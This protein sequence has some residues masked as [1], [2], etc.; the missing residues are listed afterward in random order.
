LCLFIHA[1]HLFSSLVHNVAH[2][3]LIASTVASPGY[4]LPSCSFAA[5][6]IRSGSNPDFRWS[7]LRGGPVCLHTDRFAQAL[8]NAHLVACGAELG[9]QL[10][11]QTK[12]P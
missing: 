12:P 2:S 9:N 3:I 8:K 4:F 7:S 1:P 10:F 5:A 6:T 11:L